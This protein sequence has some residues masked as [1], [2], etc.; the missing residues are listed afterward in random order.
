[1][2]DSSKNILAH[3]GAIDLNPKGM[4][5]CPKDAEILQ[6]A[7][8]FTQLALEAHPQA[9]GTRHEGMDSHTGATVFS[10]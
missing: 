5:V 3:P 6:E 1:M 7:A 9:E 8:L 4:E 2:P 10:S